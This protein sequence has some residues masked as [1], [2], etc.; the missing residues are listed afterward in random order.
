MRKIRDETVMK[1]RQLRRSP[2]LPESLLWQQLRAR[3]QGLEFRRQHP[4]GSF[5]VDFYCPAIRL[6]VEVDGNSHDMGDR[7]ARD[8]RRDLYLRQNGLRVL[9]LDAADVMRDV[10]S[11]VTTI[12]AVARG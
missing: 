3:P 6:V 12:L 2:T 1:A 10:G 7:P 4:F 9:R 5:I 8:E 11:A